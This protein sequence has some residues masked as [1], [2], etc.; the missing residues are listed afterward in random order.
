MVESSISKIVQ[1]LIENDLPIQDALARGYGNYSAIARIL[2]PRVE[3][4]YG[5]KVD[6]AGVITAVKR[7]RVTYT[8]KTEY[9][10]IVAESRITLRTD[11][12]KISVEKTRRSLEKARLISA[13][14]PEAFFQVLEGASTLTLITDEGIFDEVRSIFRKEEILGEKQNLAALIVQSPHEIVDTPGCIVAFY[15]P[16]SR[17]YINIEETVSC[18]TETIIVLRME[19]AA[20]AFS[21]LS[22]LIF[23]MRKDAR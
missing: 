15:N 14:F 7:A 12:A 18:F 10:K 19:D 16:I 21:I 8:P 6:I 5:R 23:R 1:N 20:K 9:H 22:D 17:A 2:K 13:D 11:V 3:E 4:I